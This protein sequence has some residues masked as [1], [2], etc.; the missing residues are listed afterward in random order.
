MAAREGFEAWYLVEQPRLANLLALAAPDLET[1]RDVTAEAFAR[2]Y[3]RWD[4]VAL[5]ERPDAWL[6]T[7][8]FNQLRRT[9]RR[10]SFE[11]R[12]LPGSTLAGSVAPGSA[13]DAVDPALWAALRSLPDRQRA[14]LALRVVHDL[15][16]NEVARL[17]GIR[18]GTVSTTLVAARAAL[19]RALPD[20]APTSAARVQPEPMVEGIRGVKP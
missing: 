8:A 7:V 4:R 10:R 3:E 19:R 1:A 11:A 17:L 14:V 9:Q 18:P 6:R 13:L 12:A 16:Q 5:M 20:H 15:S 2:A